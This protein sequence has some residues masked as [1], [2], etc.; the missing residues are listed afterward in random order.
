MRR[1]TFTVAAFFRSF[2]RI[3]SP[4]LQFR[5]HLSRV[6]LRLRTGVNPVL[7]LR[8]PQASKQAADRT[9]PPPVLHFRISPAYRSIYP[10]YKTPWGT[11][12]T[13]P[14]QGRSTFPISVVRWRCGGGLYCPSPSPPGFPLSKDKKEGFALSA[15]FGRSGRK[16]VLPRLKGGGAAP[17]RSR[18]PRSRKKRKRPC[19]RFFL[20]RSASCL[21]RRHTTTAGRTPPARIFVFPSSLA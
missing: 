5:T 2:S 16:P 6:G 13:K 17:G 3:Y 4:L 10:H 14:A 21:P 18:G 7:R 9:A 8:P 15:P 1:M 11:Q 20:C 19:L 12:R